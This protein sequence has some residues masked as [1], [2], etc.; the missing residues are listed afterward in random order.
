MCLCVCVR[1]CL[2]LRVRENRLLTD[3]ILHSV[4][5]GQDAIIALWTAAFQF[6]CDMDQ[7]GTIH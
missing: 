4:P 3:A 5:I 2:C 6:H 7:R 1:L